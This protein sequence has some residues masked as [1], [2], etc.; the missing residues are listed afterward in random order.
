MS[1]HIAIN[2]QLARGQSVQTVQENAH[3]ALAVMAFVQEE[4]SLSE[5]AKI[6]DKHQW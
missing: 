6:L 5:L 2:D 3:K 4:I 1:V